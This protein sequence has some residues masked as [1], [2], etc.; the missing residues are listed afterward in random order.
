MPPVVGDELT[1]A[2]EPSASSAVSTGWIGARADASMGSAVGSSPLDTAP[3]R[4]RRIH[5]G[6]ASFTGTS[7]SPLS[8]EVAVGTS[9][10]GLADA[11][12][13][14]AAAVEAAVEIAGCCCIGV[15][16]TCAGDAR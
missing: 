15:V 3:S 1:D 2:V 7:A 4:P 10:I 14:K 6:D 8:A 12:A 5:L 13:W 9:A 11:A 16:C